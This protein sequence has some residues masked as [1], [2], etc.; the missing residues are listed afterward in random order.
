MPKPGYTKQGIRNLDGPPKN[1]RTTPPEAGCFHVWRHSPGCSG[2]DVAY[3][4]AQ[5]EFHSCEYYCVK[6]PARKS[7]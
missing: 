3:L 1:A 5:S 7:E 4:Y 2:C 6:C